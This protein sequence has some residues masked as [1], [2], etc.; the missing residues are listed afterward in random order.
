MEQKQHIF[1]VGG[2]TASGK[3]D[4]AI[5]IAHHFNCPIINADSRQVYKELQIGTAR[6]FMSE[7]DGVPHH[8]MGHISIHNSYTTG[9]WQQEVDALLSKELAQEPI[10]VMVGG[11]GLYL[12]SALTGLDDLPRTEPETRTHVELLLKSRGIAS[13]IEYLTINDPEILPSLDHKNHRRLMRPVEIHMQTGKS[14]SWWLNNQIKEPKPYTSTLFIPD[15]EREILY[16]R[17]NK[18]VFQM[19][20]KGLL[21]EVKSVQ[22]YLG[23]IQALSTV[24]YQEFIAHFAGEASK[25]ETIAKIQQNTRRYAKRQGTFFRKLGGEILSFEMNDA[26]LHLRLK[27]AFAERK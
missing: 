25:G 5:R 7:Y 21:E 15:I 8:L 23:E 17:I 2:P 10:V 26:D 16:E 18:R 19:M 3:S 11:T 1:V 6:P 12:Q 4:F 24:G 22:E 9:I 20:E 13:L 27:R 14:M